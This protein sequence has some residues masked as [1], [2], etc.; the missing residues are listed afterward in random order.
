MV[1]PNPNRATTQDSLDVFNQQNK[2]DDYYKKKNYELVGTDKTRLTSN[3]SFNKYLDKDYEDFVTSKYPTTILVN[4]RTVDV[5][6]D[7]LKDQYRKV[8]NKNQL[9]QKESSVQ[10]LD[11]KAPTPLYDRRIK[12]QFEKTYVNKDKNDP[13]F[14]DSINLMTYDPI[15]VK[16]LSKMTP[17][18]RKIREERYPESIPKSIPVKPK[19]DVPEKMESKD[20]SFQSIKTEKTDERKPKM[21]PISKPAQKTPPALQYP[22][23]K[24][25]FL[26]KVKSFMTGK[27]EMPYWTDKQGEKHYPSRGESNPEEVKKIK[28]LKSGLNPLIPEDAKELK[29]IDSLLKMNSK[30]RLNNILPKAADGMVINNYKA[31]QSARLPSKTKK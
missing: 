18:E 28:M 17:A 5:N 26:E 13:L 21:R 24:Q 20:A 19:I 23:M 31:M 22:S 30:D 6:K 9:Y 14:N 8:K 3:S 15:A 27:K 16:P 1:A 11:T 12:P 7:S 25:T 4:K 29:R 10:I 2:V